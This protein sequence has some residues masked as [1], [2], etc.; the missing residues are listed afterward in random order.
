[1]AN[2]MSADAEGVPHD[3][4]EEHCC[5]YSWLEDYFERLEGKDAYRAFQ[6]HCL[7]D[8]RDEYCYA[9]IASLLA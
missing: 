8:G 5:Y 3:E 9:L 7:D 2:V 6:E 1:M 4:E